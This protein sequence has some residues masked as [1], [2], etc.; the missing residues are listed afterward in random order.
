MQKELSSMAISAIAGRVFVQVSFLHALI[1]TMSCP[2]PNYY[3]LPLQ[4]GGHY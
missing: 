2:F 1:K 3:L 4:L